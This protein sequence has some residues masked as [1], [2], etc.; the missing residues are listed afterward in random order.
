MFKKLI[1]AGLLAVAIFAGGQAVDGSVAAAQ[2]VYAGEDYAPQ[3]RRPVKLY[4]MTDTIEIKREDSVFIFS[5]NYKM[6]YNDGDY[7]EGYVGYYSLDGRYAPNSQW[8]TCGHPQGKY[9]RGRI[10]SLTSKILTVC[11][12][13]L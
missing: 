13:Y 10:N 9:Y 5:V 7:D 2:D 4:V 3:T 12:E 6:V 11:K 8:T 1:T